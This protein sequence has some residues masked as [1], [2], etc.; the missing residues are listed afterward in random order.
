MEV[1]KKLI[2]TALPGPAKQNADLEEEGGGPC[3][4]RIYEQVFFFLAYKILVRN[5]LSQLIN[6]GNEVGGKCRKDFDL[7]T[8]TKY[9]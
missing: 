3:W 9:Y 1:K 7:L 6:A 2:V 8:D 5:K 4:C